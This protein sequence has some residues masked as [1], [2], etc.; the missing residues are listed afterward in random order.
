MQNKEILRVAEEV[1]NEKGVDREIIFEALETALAGFMPSTQT[2][3]R[4]GHAQEVRRGNRRARRD[5]PQDR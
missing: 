4:I 3:E 2:L 1:S 5:Q